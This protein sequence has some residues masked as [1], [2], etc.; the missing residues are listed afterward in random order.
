MNSAVIV[1]T[2]VIL[3]LAS[4][5][6]LGV[7]LFA[8]SDHRSDSFWANKSGILTLGAIAVALHALA[9][10]HNLFTDPGLNLGFSSAVSLVTWTI[11]ALLVIASLTQPLESLGIVILPAAALALVVDKVFP[12][13]HVITDQLSPEL[14]LHI[15]VSIMAY[16]VLSI[17]AVQSVLLAIQDRQLRHRHP[18]GFIRALPPLQTMETLLFQMIG[19]GFILHSLALLTGALY[20]EDMFAQHVA[21][22]TVL[23]L[24]SWVVFATLLWGRWHSGWRGPTAIRWTLSGFTVL[25]LAYF[26]SK[27]VLEVLLDRY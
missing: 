13:A 19:L 10:S 27:L 8:R 2:T 11:A 22:K 4:A 23:S 25:L 20:M 21:H 9:L 15:V 26:G 6:M 5:A 12:T 18:G 16:G 7:R 17:A 3:Y 1:A 24:A 14:E